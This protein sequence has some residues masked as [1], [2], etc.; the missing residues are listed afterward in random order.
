[1]ARRRRS[2]A[3]RPKEAGRASGEPGAPAPRIYPDPNHPNMQRAARTVSEI[4]WKYVT[5]HTA[6]ECEELQR[7]VQADR[8]AAERLFGTPQPVRKDDGGAHD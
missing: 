1:M 3:V 7:Q 2:R 4:I 6:E 5:T 8:I